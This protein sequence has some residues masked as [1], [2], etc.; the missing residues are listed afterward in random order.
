MQ[1]IP[2]NSRTT[3]YIDTCDVCGTPWFSSKLHVGPDGLKR[4]PSH[5][6]RSKFEIDQDD[7]RV[8]Q[9]VD[10]YHPKERL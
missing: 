4:C 10:R 2:T 5:R 8:L 6:G 9:Q 7:A 1:T 3:D